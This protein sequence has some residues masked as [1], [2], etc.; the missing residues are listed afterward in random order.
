MGVCRVVLLGGGVYVRVRSLRR[1]CSV[2]LTPTADGHCFLLRENGT[3]VS[4][5]TGAAAAPLH[6]SHAGAGKA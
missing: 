3:V 1:E 4:V 5:P 2:W 6:A